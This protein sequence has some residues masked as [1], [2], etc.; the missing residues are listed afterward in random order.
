MTNADLATAASDAETLATPGGDDLL[1]L[2]LTQGER[3]V[4][5]FRKTSHSQR[6]SM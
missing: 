3:L 5:P 1:A 2:L 4:R 6:V